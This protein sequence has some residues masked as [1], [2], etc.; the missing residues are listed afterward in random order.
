MIKILHTFQVKGSVIALYEGE[1]HLAFTDNMGYLYIVNKKNSSMDTYYVDN[2]ISEPLHPYQ[3]SSAFSQFGELL[4]GVD[5]DGS[6]AIKITPPSPLENRTVTTVTKAREITTKKNY[7]YGN[8][9][10]VESATFAGE[11]SEYIFTGGTDGKVFMYSAVT[12]DVLL[13][14]KSLP[15]YIAHISNDPTGRFLSFICYNRSLYVMDLHY[16]EE[17]LNTY[18]GDVIEDS[19]FF[20]NCK[21]LY[22]VSRDGVSCIYDLKEK[23]LSNKKSIFLSWPTCCVLEKSSRYAI[24]GTRSGHIH[25]VNLQDN[26][27]ASTE[28]LDQ[29][30]IVSCSLKDSKLLIGF[31]NG[32]VYYIDLYAYED[33]FVE[34]LELK[35]FATTKKCLDKN[36]FLAIHPMSALFYDAWDEII[37][38][39]R[40]QF[41]RGNT[42]SALETAAPFLSDSANKNEFDFLVQKQKDFKKFAQLVDNNHYFEAYGMLELAPYLS[43]TESAKKL[44][45][46]FVK[47]FA[48]AK[49][50]IATDPLRSL[51][52]VKEM[53]KPFAS[54]DSKSELIRALIQNHQVFLKA[55]EYIKTKNFKSFFTLTEQF[56]FLRD[57]EIY[58]RVC[59]VA[60]N[61]INKIKKMVEAHHYDDAIGAIKQF[62]VFTPYKA[63]LSAL[64]NRIQ[65]EMKLITLIETNKIKDVYEF[66]KMYPELESLDAFI[67]YENIFSHKLS[68]AMILVGQGEIKKTQEMLAEYCSISRFK[69]K[70][71]ECIRQAT[72]NRLTNLLLHKKIEETKPVMAYYLKEF[73]KDTHI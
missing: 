35:D 65:L 60:E 58:R 30:G 46:A 15:D 23:K 4:Y 24:V 45:A 71:K 49:K 3:K 6:C 41:S 32:S 56:T 20:D 26:T 28:K 29:R 18:P 57:E 53:L 14:L 69:P 51:P 55:D 19:F 34:S 47:N 70:I 21:Q 48:L 54:V 38:E 5:T 52:K 10:R 7:L 62:A 67:Q 25:L 12:G 43:K 27:I 31:E 42:Q 8:D 1:E 37:K 33:Q 44:N 11:H 64:F 61:A 17:I 13:S 66:I 9:N 73:G 16:N 2:E 63:T 40:E 36:F 59:E 39:I 72:F 68:D 22:A 50:M